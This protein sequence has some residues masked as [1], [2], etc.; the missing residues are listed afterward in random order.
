MIECEFC[1]K[2]CH[3]GWRMTFHNDIICENCWSEA[4]DWR[5]EDRQFNKT[6][7]RENDE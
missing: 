7:K 6:Q 1:G 3:K 4:I 5:E 2:E